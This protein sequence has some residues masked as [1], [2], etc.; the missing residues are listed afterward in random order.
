M[1]ARNKGIS[2][3]GRLVLVLTFQTIVD[4]RRQRSSL[5]FNPFPVLGESSELS[6]GQGE[7]FGTPNKNYYGAAWAAWG[8]EWLLSFEVPAPLCVPSLLPGSVLQ[9]RQ[10][11]WH[12]CPPQP[13]PSS[14]SL[15][16]P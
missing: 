1:A 2:P 10:K 16:P 7:T 8:P 15:P 13:P 5:G 6:V 14:L 11:D 3:F 12:L 9:R 4:R